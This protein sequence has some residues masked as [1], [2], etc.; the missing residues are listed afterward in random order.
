MGRIRRRVKALLFFLAALL[1]YYA[2]G[3]TTGNNKTEQQQKPSCHAH[4]SLKDFKESEPVN[5]TVGTSATLPC[6]TT[7]QIHVNKD[8][9]TWRKGSTNVLNWKGKQTFEKGNNVIPPSIQQVERGDGSIVL[10]RVKESDEGEYCCC[11]H[12]FGNMKCIIVTLV[13]EENRRVTPGLNRHQ[14]VASTVKPTRNTTISGATA[15][16]IAIV[17]AVLLVII[18][19]LI[20]IWCKVKKCCLKNKSQRKNSNSDQAKGTEDTAIQMRLMDNR[21][22][23]SRAIP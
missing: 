3:G 8:T 7:L 21:D 1:V 5:A 10:S 15:K 9:L 20:W 22:H 19:I 18:V 11:F 4:V 6:H 12:K 2:S 16:I 14:I 17:A 23:T 13:V